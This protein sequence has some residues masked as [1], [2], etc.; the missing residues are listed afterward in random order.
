METFP[1]N[2]LRFQ[3]R[4][5]VRSMN[6]TV[7]C[8]GCL[9]IAAILLLPVMLCSSASGQSVAN[10]E[11]HGVVQDPT[12]AVVS[13]AKITATQTDTGH[14]QSAVSGSDGSFLL[15]GLPVGSYTLEIVAPSFDRY[16]QRGIVLQVGQNVQ[17]NVPLTAGAVTQEVQVSADANMVETQGTAVSEVIDQKRIVDIPLNGRQITDL[18]LL[19]GG[20][21]SPPNGGSRVVTSHDYPNSAAISVNGGQINGNNFL[22]DG[23]DHNDSHS[24][25]NMPF[26]FPDALQ[27]FSVQT[28]GISARFGL[29]P[30]SVVN[31]VTKSGT[32][33]IHGDLFEFVRNGD[34]N[35]RFFPAVVRDSLKRNQYGGTIGGP[36]LKNKIFLFGGFQETAIRT[37]PATTTAYVATQQELNGDFSTEESSTCQTG[38]AKILND[39][40][41]GLPFSP[42]NQINPSRYT[43][44]SKALLGLIPLSSDPCGKLVFAI[45]NPSN[46][47]QYVSRMDWNQSAKNTVM[48]RYFILDYTNPP[49]YTNNVLTTARAGSAQRAQSIVLGDQ[50]ALTPNLLNSF[51]LGFTRLAIHRTNPSNMPNMQTLGSNVNTAQPNFTDLTVT[52][53][54]TVG[55]SSNAPA[56]YIR[57]Q[58]QYAD[59]IDFVRGRNHMS[60]GGEFLA[61]QMDAT[62]LTYA[63]GE[64]NFKAAP[65]TPLGQENSLS[66]Y[67]VGDVSTFLDSNLVVSGLR[68]KYIGA[69]FQDDFQATRNLN[70][71]AGLRWEPLLPE[72]DAGGRGNSFSMAN[73]TAGTRTGL[74]TNAPPGLLFYGD[75]GIPKAY[76]RGSR[77]DL[78]PRF[79]FAWDPSGVGKESVRGSYGVFFDQPESYTNS[80]F[81]LDAPWGNTI[82]L[83]NPSGGLVNPFASYP[84]G[85][86]YP[87]AVPPN[88]NSVFPTGA[89][90]FFI[91]L[92][93][94][95]P[96]MQ[97][98]GLSLERQLGNDWV[99]DV[100]YLGNQGTHIRAGNELDPAVYIPG[101]WTGPGGC[102]ALTVSPGTGKPC[103][104]TANTQQRRTLSLQNPAT[105]AYYASMSNLDDSDNTNYH[106]LRLSAKHRFDHSFSILS[107]YTWSKCLQDYET[108][109]NKI[110]V[111]ESN[112]FNKAVD[113]GPCDYNLKNNF[114]TSV[115]YEGYKFT[116]RAVDFAAGRWQIA[117]VETIYNGFPINVLSGADNSFSGVGLDRANVVPGVNPYEKNRATHQWI[118]PAAFAPN[119]AG[120]FGTA[121]Y[122]S[123]VGP[124]FVNTDANLSKIFKTYKEQNL[125]LRFEFFDLF[126]HTNYALPVATQNSA[127]F[128]QIQSSSN[129]TSGGRILQ[130]AAKY[131]F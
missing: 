27:E 45:P 73:F 114:V 115:I 5:F 112:P 69:Y 48:A 23:A 90:Y 87:I 6:L 118:N 67:L 122:N 44:P 16:L 116:N 78:A 94:H 20:A 75:A 100:D 25:I 111:T 55:G 1:I 34:L 59:D 83:N 33:S 11:I 70:L 10:A 56:D 14:V 47:Y 96:Y 113:Y 119:P 65:A 17:V 58:W 39:P 129:A 130:L 61:G 124:H 40:A 91:P 131:T 46:E 64:F 93:L 103:S 86:P 97:Q 92:N 13:G 52:S 127:T 21:A 26:P 72:Y 4:H 74:Y 106:A 54:F 35:A 66:D 41:T 68:Q 32:N 98:W 88:Q 63:N 117:F 29:H 42:T 77:V 12:G 126:N 3:I 9:L 7:S 36:I 57:N 62:N 37:A 8:A 107:V 43:V 128:G 109:P 50:Y 104:S 89:A 71:H 80:V 30:G 60:F 2:A 15:P 38:G 49:I 19:S 110:A 99:I 22:L 51:H 108:L 31:V 120:T 53:F 102:G 101:V 82:T 76:G 85:N 105:G 125:Q 95:H 123:L 28:S 18:V 79:G 121:S 84:G 24:N 81:A